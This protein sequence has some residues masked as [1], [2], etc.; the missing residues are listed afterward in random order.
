MMDDVFP[1]DVNQLQMVKRQLD[2]L[3]KLVDDL[4]LLSLARAGQLVIRKTKF[5]LHNLV[6]ERLAW[7]KT[8]LDETGIAHHVRIPSN[9]HLLADKDRM[10]QVLSILIDNFIRY[11][12]QG[13]ELDISAR[14]VEQ[15]LLLVFADRGPGIEVEDLHHVF[16]RFWRAERSRA[17]HSGGSGLGLS[18]ARAIC[19]AHGADIN[20]SNRE[21]GGALIEIAIP[22]AD[23]G[24]S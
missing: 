15:K 18:I 13:G 23:V 4:H 24:F 17:R 6:L 11:A 21:G 12:S 8:A 20:V 19:L 3:S 5:S 14:I 2:Q 22:L 16:E 1:R 7:F 9:L 10:G